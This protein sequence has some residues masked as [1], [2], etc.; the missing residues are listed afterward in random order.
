MRG[1]LVWEG[2]RASRGQSTC[3]FWVP[4]EGD[5]EGLTGLI[6]RGYNGLLLATSRMA[7]DQT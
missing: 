4:Y 6:C 1:H 7:I 2:T 5:G 3:L